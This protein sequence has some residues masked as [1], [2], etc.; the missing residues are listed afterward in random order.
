MTVVLAWCHL[1]LYWHEHVLLVS[2][3]FFLSSVL[4]LISSE[5]LTDDSYST[6]KNCCWLPLPQ[7]GRLRQRGY[8]VP[9]ENR[10]N[11]IQMPEVS[12]SEC[13]QHTVPLVALG[14][15]SFSHLAHVWSWARTLSLSGNNCNLTEHWSWKRSLNPTSLHRKAWCKL[16]LALAFLH[17][18]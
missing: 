7:M 3:C 18:K 6:A 16:K 11:Q 13:C 1:R 17:L 8:K 9:P 5:W 14:E 12:L 15:L 2:C 10:E 4:P